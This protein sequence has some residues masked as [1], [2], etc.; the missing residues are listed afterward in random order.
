M[1]TD[2][3]YGNIWDIW[4]FEYGRNL[5]VSVDAAKNKDFQHGKINVSC[6]PKTSNIY[7]VVEK[8]ELR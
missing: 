3:E 7:D 6:S 8:K 1:L 4:D 5:V 2:P